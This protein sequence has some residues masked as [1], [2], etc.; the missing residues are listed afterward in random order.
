MIYDNFKHSETGI[1]AWKGLDVRKTTDRPWYGLASKS[2]LLFQV[3]VIVLSLTRSGW[4]ERVGF[5][6]PMS[7]E[8]FWRFGG[9]SAR[10]CNNKVIIITS[11]K[12][13]FPPSVEWR[14]EFTWICRYQS[15]GTETAHWNFEGFKMSH[16]CKTT[17]LLRQGFC[18]KKSV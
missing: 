4:S 8:F 9:R 14:L 5:F 7:G 12:C 3:L 13:T 2:S 6:F 16:S 17:T 1:P 15:E 11:L 18:T 10:I